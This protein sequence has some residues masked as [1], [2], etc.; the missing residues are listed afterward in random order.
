MSVVLSTPPP[1]LSSFRSSRRPR[2]GLSPSSMR[3]AAPSSTRST[4][5]PS[6][7]PP[8]PLP[9]AP[10]AR[11]SSTS[12]NPPSSP[13]RRRYSHNTHS[14][15]QHLDR[16]R[17]P[18][19]KPSS[20]SAASLEASSGSGSSGTRAGRRRSFAAGH[21]TGSGSKKPHKDA[22]RGRS[23][24]AG[25]QGGAAG[26]N[27]GSVTSPHWMGEESS[28]APGGDSTS[29]TEGEGW[30]R[31]GSRNGLPLT[32][33][34]TSTTTNASPSQSIS[35]R[36]S[37][38]QFP[39]LRNHDS[40]RSSSATRSRPLSSSTH[41]GN[42][43]H[44][45]HHTHHS[46]SHQSSRPASAPLLPLE[47]QLSLFG[48]KDLSLTISRT[49]LESCLVLGAV[50]GGAYGLQCRDNPV[51]HQ[52][53][54]EILSVMFLS[55]SYVLLRSISPPGSSRHSS[56]KTPTHAPLPFQSRSTHPLRPP[57]SSAFFLPLFRDGSKG[58]VWGTDDRD[59]RD[60]PDDGALISFLFGPLLAASLLLTTLRQLEQPTLSSSLPR[61]WFVESPLIVP[62]SFEAS[63]ASLG[64]S[65]V[66]T[67]VVEDMN[68]RIALEA[69]AKSRR[70]MLSLS[71]VIAV[72]LLLQ[73]LF[74][75]WAE[76]VHAKKK[77][78]LVGG[79][80]DGVAVGLPGEKWW[81][82]RSEWKR[83]GSVVSFGLAVS[84]GLGC[85]KAGFERWSI[86]VW[87][88]ESTI[89]DLSLRFGPNDL[90]RVY[91]SLGFRFSVFL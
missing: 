34:A 64:A 84:I 72:V 38:A 89:Y 36:P 86:P 47:L 24:G 54:M 57:R 55:L 32:T 80:R 82:P 85:I 62:P 42:A 78:A 22:S 8:P 51:D 12:V 28:S 17:L 25:L 67:L 60:E 5:S 76:A 43:S 90:P 69:L 66:S 27:E 20:A 73:L 70:S 30:S 91:L 68:P 50:V 31:W 88:S 63:S 59:Y 10:M 65:A 33:F 16:D 13:T 40:T 23:V 74:S 9:L 87:T 46:S 21:N 18:S 56:P 53:A 81:L 11:V 29:A 45:A 49:L 79:E 58:F 44:H 71:S 39:H 3:V 1:V 52:S 4:P 2:R 7:P 26:G 37:S 35:S 6:P 75:R 77:G 61:D 41:L 48:G 83:T 15:A 14:H 19:P